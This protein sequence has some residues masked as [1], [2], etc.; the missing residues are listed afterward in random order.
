MNRQA[1]KPSVIAHAGCCGLSGMTVGYIHAAIAA[2]AQGVE[3]D[4][5]TTRDGMAV[6]AHN[7]VIHDQAG[8]LLDLHQADLAEARRRQPALTTLDE[9]LPIVR[10]HGLWLNIDIKSL[11]AV[12]A[13]AAGIQAHQC[14]DL[15]YLT[16]LTLADAAAV[17]EDWP[18]LSV[19]VNLHHSGRLM[20]SLPGLCR[21]AEQDTRQAKTIGAAGINLEWRLCSKAWVQLIHNLKLPVSCWTVDRPAIIRKVIGWDIDFLTTNRPD[22]VSSLSG[23]SV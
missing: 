17:I 11:S 18:V 8:L 2:G 5:N 4:L 21:L 1:R 20:D 14:Q 3:I 13:A 19:F 22:L 12:P 9:V 16:G 15:A 10:Q 6:L 23:Q 7:D